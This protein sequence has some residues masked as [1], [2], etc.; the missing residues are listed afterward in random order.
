MLTAFF[1]YPNERKAPK[2]KALWVQFV[3]DGTRLRKAVE[4]KSA[5][6]VDTYRQSA[7]EANTRRVEAAARGDIRAQMALDGSNMPWMNRGSANTEGA[8]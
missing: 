1:E 3:F 2:D 6:S 8:S 5:S 7:D 4:N